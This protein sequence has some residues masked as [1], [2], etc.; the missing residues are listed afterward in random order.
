MTADPVRSPRKL[1]F[2]SIT[3]P[4][5]STQQNPITRVLS[6]PIP[7]DQ[8]YNEDTLQHSQSQEVASSNDLEEQ[9]V[10]EKLNREKIKKDLLKKIIENEGE[11][12]KEKKSPTPKEAREHIKRELFKKKSE[13]ELPKAKSEEGVNIEH[14]LVKNDLVKID[15]VR[16]EFKSEGSKPDSNA[17]LRKAHHV[18]S[19]TDTHYMKHLAEKVKSE[20]TEKSSITQETNLPA[21]SNSDGQIEKM[22]EP[23]ELEKRPSWK[24]K[25]NSPSSLENRIILYDYDQKMKIEDTL[26]TL[27]HQVLAL[28]TSY[29]STDDI[30]TLCLTCKTYKKHFEESPIWKGMSLKQHL[31]FL[32]EDDDVDS[33]E[34][35][36]EFEIE[37]TH[38]LVRRIVKKKINFFFNSFKKTI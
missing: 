2:S 12:V 30:L 37:K 31:L 3:S 24:V 9:I 20:T 11:E 1:S 38:G 6:F 27:P 36:I 13:I 33:I 17:K 29:L 26:L 18:R 15:L 28:I 21:F 7:F 5:V 35:G 32:L 4:I 34:D 14:D 8:Q 10:D 25:L 22:E 19:E 16:N 23:P